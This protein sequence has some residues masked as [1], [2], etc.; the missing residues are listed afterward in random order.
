M[1]SLALSRHPLLL[2]AGQRLK[3]VRERRVP[4]RVNPAL[5]LHSRMA[6]DELYSDIS[7][8][9]AIPN[10]LVT[11][12]V[13]RD[14][15][16]DMDELTVGLQDIVIGAQ[17]LSPARYLADKSAYNN[18]NISVLF[19]ADDG[20]NFERDVS[21]DGFSTVGAAEGSMPSKNIKGLFQI[22]GRLPGMFEL[23][24]VAI[25]IVRY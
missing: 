7:D 13:E 17:E 4:A 21:D 23:F 15:S 22:L 2:E 1:K 11:P 20:E 12:I 24:Q 6:Q 5:A 16:Y 25:L 9:D 10:R 19:D 14:A 3:E 8:T 18:G